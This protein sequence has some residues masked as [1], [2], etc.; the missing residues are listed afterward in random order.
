MRIQVVLVCLFQPSFAVLFR[1]AVKTKPDF[2]K[3]KTRL[4]CL[5]TLSVLEMQHVNISEGSLKCLICVFHIFEM[6]PS[7]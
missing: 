1:R 6:Y 7:F 2:E 3:K 4:L 5:I